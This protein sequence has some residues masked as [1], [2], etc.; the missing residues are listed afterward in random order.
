[1]AAIG[2][3]D[4]FFNPYELDDNVNNQV[5]VDPDIGV[6]DE[7]AYLL[8]RP[9]L[10]R[11]TTN[12]TASE[13]EELCSLVC[14][15]IEL[16]ARSTGE[17]RGAG[18]RPPKL[19][20]EQRLLSFILH[21]KHDNNFVYDSGKWN[22]AKSSH[23]DDAIFVATCINEAILDQEIYWPD[24]H[25]RK[26]LGRTLPEMP[27]CIGNIDGTL[28]R[29]PRPHNNPEH[30]RWFNGRKK[31]YAMN[32]TVVIDHFGLI[33]YVD[34]GYPGSFHDVNCLRQ[35]NL[36]TNWREHFTHDDD[37]QYFEYLL[38][39]PGY[40]GME[41]FVMGRARDLELEGID[42]DVL[43]AFNKMHGGYR[44]RVE[45]G[46]GGVKRKWKR[47]MKGFDLRKPKFSIMFRCG[48]GLTNFIHRRRM[49]MEAF[50]I[51]RVPHQDLYGWDG[52]Y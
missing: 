44:V 26:M 27:G 39:D 40:L 1:M 15:V 7:L 11:A 49:D 4:E 24:E 16:Y 34:P 45:W 43:R 9:S 3:T 20:P 21:F 17:I 10:F 29:I 30:G 19:S 41:M 6:R 22:W 2:N 35:S 31:M 8:R 14:P 37:E 23:C 32:N 28:V 52:D 25:E 42:N 13:F 18:G 5:Y 51:E 47:L 48:C 36:A 12:F 50:D 46:I 33:R 38:G